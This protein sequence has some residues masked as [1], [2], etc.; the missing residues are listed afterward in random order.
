[1]THKGAK[2]FL[3]ILLTPIFFILSFIF[4]DVFFEY[5]LSGLPDVQVYT[6]NILGS[7]GSAFVFA[8]AVGVLPILLFVSDLGVNYQKTWKFL[9]TLFFTLFM[10]WLFVYL[11]LVYIDSTLESTQI[12]PNIQNSIAF[13]NIQAEYYLGFG[14][15]LGML[16]STLFFMFFGKSEE[17]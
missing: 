16:T 9:S 8:S 3:A 12:A 13:D 6:T 5:V 17:A 4:S 14:F 15:L 1:M 11:R 10:G 2:R 7:P